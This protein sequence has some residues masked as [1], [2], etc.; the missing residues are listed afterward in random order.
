MF[1]K[2]LIEDGV[3]HEDGSSEALDVSDDSSRVLLVTLGITRTIEQE[4]LDVAIYGSE[5]GSTWGAKPLLA[6]PQK[7]YCG[8]YAMLLDLAPESNIRYIRA[9]WKMNR[10]GRGEPSATFAF[11]LA[12][13]VAHV[14]PLAAASA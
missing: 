8:A 2:F 12:A 9:Q 14:R 5:D 4:S 3:R 13:E 6:F 7:F 11:Y 10:W 1:P